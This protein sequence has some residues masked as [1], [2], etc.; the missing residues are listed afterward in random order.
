MYIF[1]GLIVIV[2]TCFESST[3]GVPFLYTLRLRW[4]AFLFFYLLLLLSTRPWPILTRVT[5]RKE[6]CSSWRVVIWLILTLFFC[7]CFLFFFTSGYRMTSFFLLYFPSPFSTNIFFSPF[8]SFFPPP[9]CLFLCSLFV[10][11]RDNFF[12]L[13]LCVCF[14]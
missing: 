7:F 13:I 8:P 5:L 3:N 1:L 10:S 4:G 14:F 2:Y 11:P 6:I 12:L 9:H